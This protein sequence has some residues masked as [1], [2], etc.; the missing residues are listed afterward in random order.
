[1]PQMMHV[2]NV[3]VGDVYDTNWT[4]IDI[5]QSV[6]HHRQMCLHLVRKRPRSTEEKFLLFKDTDIISIT[7]GGK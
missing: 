3:V 5:Y 4:V 6:F 1:M 2:Y 7:P